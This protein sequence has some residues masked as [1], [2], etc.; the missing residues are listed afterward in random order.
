MAAQ[1][2]FLP[3]RARTCKRRCAGLRR[4]RWRAWSF[5]YEK[6]LYRVCPRGSCQKRKCSQGLSKFIYLE[7]GEFFLVAKSSV[8]VALS[9]KTTSIRTMQG[10]LKSLRTLSSLPSYN[11]RTPTRSNTIPQKRRTN[12]NQSPF[13]TSMLFVLIS[14]LAWLNITTKHP[15]PESQLLPDVRLYCLNYCPRTRSLARP[16]LH[17]VWG[18]NSCKWYTRAPLH[19]KQDNT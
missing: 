14:R 17:E 3:S 1:R 19:R 2:C 12:D 4:L 18:C 11:T 7:L 9:A 15:P 16:Y 8:A 13:T 5:A 6:G 10:N